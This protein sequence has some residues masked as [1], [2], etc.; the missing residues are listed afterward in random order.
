[1]KRFVLYLGFFVLV[2]SQLQ[3]QYFD[4]KSG[5]LA[6]KPFYDYTSFNGSDFGAVRQFQ[7]GFELGYV[8]NFSNNISLIIPVGAGIRRDSLAEE[9]K[10]PF[11]NLGAQGQFHLLKNKWVSPYLTGGVNVILPKGA[12][13]AVQIPLGI[14]FNFM[15]HPQAYLQWQSDYRFSIA[16]WPSHLQHQLG[17]VYMLGN[18]KMSSPK[19][20]M[21]KTDSDGDG[22][23]DELDLCPSI[24]G[25]AKFSGCPD[26]DE[27]G[28]PDYKDKCPEQSGILEFMG[29]PDSDKDGIPDPEDECPTVAGPKN[30]N[31]CPP[32]D[33]D[34]DGVP[35]KDD[36][37]PDKAGLASLFGCPDSDGDGV[38]DKDDRCPNVPGKKEKGGCPD[39][40]QSKD[41]D[42]DGIEDEQ[43]ECPFTA[44]LIQFKGCP[45]TDGDGI[46]DK[47]DQCPTSP[48]P[49]S[50]NGCPVIEKA[51]REVLDFAMRAVQFDLGKSTLKQESFK[52]LDKIAIILKKYDA[53]NLAIGGHTD[54]TGSAKFN[55]DLSERRAKVC[56]EYL[57]S[58]GVSQSRLSYAGY[59]ATQPVADNKTENGRFLNR[60]TEFNLIPR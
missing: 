54:N 55:L 6:R 35:D 58:K 14:G 59:G 18:K 36:H 28:V 57:I 25:L 16:N 42:N 13:L 9:L 11:I 37:C 22:I 49:K 40:A 32:S 1:M 2:V 30:N 20:E 27:D 43:D 41:A 47:H 4:F 24:A 29:C 60:R 26:T 45:D 8:R 48:G 17:F 19:I 38:S 7:N 5:I 56:Y 39:A 23:P 33:K 3:A 34:G 50:N 21:S 12:D 51:D 52:I 31:G 15:F 53:Y 46:Q 10:L 44:G